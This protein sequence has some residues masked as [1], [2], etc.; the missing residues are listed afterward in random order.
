MSD[1][2]APEWHREWHE[3]R[4]LLGCKWTLHVLRLLSTDS[5]GFNEIQRELDGLTPTM[6]SRRLTQLTE[7]GLVNRELIPDSPP[8]TRYEL[9]E[10][11][12]AFTEILR[13]LEQFTPLVEN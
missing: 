4:S 13:Q 11:G 7:Y 3:L 8:R 9:T 5:Y 12:V 1:T 6:L 2:D 10:T